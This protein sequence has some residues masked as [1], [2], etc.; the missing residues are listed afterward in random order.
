MIV[1]GGELGYRLW[2]LAAQR[3]KKC[4]YLPSRK[5][6]FTK[7][8]FFFFLQSSLELVGGKIKRATWILFLI[9]FHGSASGACMPQQNK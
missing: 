2:G 5:N 6:I 3:W 7:M 1:S 4:R 8:I 9:S